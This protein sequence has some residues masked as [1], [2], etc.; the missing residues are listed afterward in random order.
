[1]NLRHPDEDAR[2]SAD[3]LDGLLAQAHWDAPAAVRVTR[4]RQALSEAVGKETSARRRR[5]GAIIGLA[6]SALLALGI[7]LWQATREDDPPRVAHPADGEPRQV[8]PP[9]SIV[10]APRNP[11][12]PSQLNDAEQPPP[13]SSRPTR[14]VDLAV[15]A[16]V[17]RSREAPLELA[18]RT[19]NAYERLVMA[20]IERRLPAAAVEVPS[21]S[22]TPIEQA[23]PVE[24]KP[25]AVDV[26]V[27]K[28][29]E[30]GEQ[31]LPMEAFAALIASLDADRP[32]HERQLLA[33]LTDPAA[34]D[35][36][37]AARLLA[38]IGA[39]A[40]LES[41]RSLFA[42]PAT[43]S[44]AAHG[45]ARLEDTTR[46]LA[47]IEAERDATVRGTLLSGLVERDEDL[48][49]AALL[50]TIANPARAEAALSAL[51]AARRPPI[52]RLFAVLTGPLTDR[53]A[54]AA[55]ALG[56]IDWPMITRRLEWL[57]AQGAYRHDALLALV[58]SRGAEAER[59]VDLARHD[60][61]LTA[62]VAWAEQQFAILFPQYRKRHHP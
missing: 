12:A 42:A 2:A 24:P 21:D 60:E 16:P 10:D 9:P 52:E 23:S 41:L 32:S 3:R 26:A 55:R 30:A 18:S 31:G 17:E 15:E 59:F 58:G 13:A 1:M 50:D 56:Q 61:T 11:T 14:P 28:L 5:F 40:A 35:R 46:L 54:L 6:A 62:S 4:L 38:E 33:R 7:G 29:V 19:P 53:R 51:A 39:P 36:P 25:S 48:A 22:V 44:A 27:G 37:E 43:H 8:A 20:T 57:V 49:V 45:L 34:T 47:L